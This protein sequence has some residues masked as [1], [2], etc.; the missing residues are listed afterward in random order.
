MT[1]GIAVTILVLIIGVAFVAGS[2]FFG[3]LSVNLSAGPEADGLKAKSFAE[4][5]AI[6]Q[7]ANLQT[8]DAD[9]KRND[10]IALDDSTRQ[11]RARGWSWVSLGFGIG[12]GVM[13]ALGMI[14]GTLLVLMRFNIG[15]MRFMISP[16][17]QSN[18]PLFAIASPLMPEYLVVAHAG[19]PGV[20][21]V[22]QRGKA[23]IVIAP[24][25]PVA[26]AASLARALENSAR[27]NASWLPFDTAALVKFSQ[28]LQGQSDNKAL[29][30]L[31]AEDDDAG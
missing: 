10:Q 26:V 31:K 22:L 27:A 3:G 13:L 5:D 20:F 21:G 16:V 25:T 9:Q 23:P 1:R 11:S 17:I 12:G 24:A 19:S 29:A 30:V 2:R 18:G 28:A 15:N 6:R 4:A 14:L 8:A 7:K